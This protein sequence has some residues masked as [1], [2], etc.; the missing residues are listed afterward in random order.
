[1]SDEDYNKRDKTFRKFRE[2]YK[3][4]QQGKQ[5]AVE[6]SAP[7]GQGDSHGC[8]P[9]VI[10]ELQ[11]ALATSQCCSVDPGNRRGIIRCRF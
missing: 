1:M 7:S 4:Q 8:D 10:E 11:S 5:D 9:V 6:G 2:Q 3:L